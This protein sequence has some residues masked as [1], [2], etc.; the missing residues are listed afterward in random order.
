MDEYSIDFKLL[1]PR[2]FVFRLDVIPF[3]V[4]YSILVYLLYTM[5][6]VGNTLIY[7][8][9]VLIAVGFLNCIITL[10]LRSYIYLWTMVEENTTAY[11]VLSNIW[12]SE[13]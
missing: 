2:A 3:I 8:R 5:E 1:R 11:S 6:D 13:R 9:L 4:L 7:L 12:P 10:Y